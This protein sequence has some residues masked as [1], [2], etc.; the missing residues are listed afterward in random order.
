VTPAQ[1]FDPDADREL[2]ASVVSS[3]PVRSAGVSAEP[4]RAHTGGTEGSD[5]SDRWHATAAGRLARFP[6]WVRTALPGAALL[7]AY[8]LLTLL[9]SPDGFLGTDTGGKVATLKA[10]AANHTFTN[11]DVGYWAA[12]WDPHGALH[13]LYYTGHIGSH[14]V[15]ATTLPMQLLGEPLYRLGGYRLALLLPIL[16]AVGCAYA[17]RALAAR[18]GGDRVRQWWAFW[19]VG[20]ASPVAIYALDFWEHSIGLALMAW[21]LVALLDLLTHDTPRARGRLG[22]LGGLAFGCAATMRTEALIYLAVTAAVVGITLLRRDRRFRPW[23]VP[24]VLTVVGAAV[25]LA[26]NRLLSQWVLGDGLRESRAGG[27]VGGAGADLALRLREGFVTTFGLSSASSNGAIVL[28]IA[29][30]AVLAIAVAR[31]G[32]RGR[33]LDRPLLVGL[34]ACAGLLYVGTFAGGLG[35]VSGITGAAPLAAAGA[36]LA[37]KNPIRRTATV[38]V[39]VALPVVWA[40]QWTGGAGPQWG[41]RYVLTTMF[42]LVVAAVVAL[43]SLKAPVP[44]VLVGL[45]VAV[46]VFGLA[47]MSVRTHDVARTMRAL[48]ARP[49]P[50][51]IADGAIGHLP[52]EGGAFYGEHRW[53][54][55]PKTENR[56]EAARVVREAGF[57][58][59]AMVDTSG[60]DLPRAIGEFTAAPS[61]KITLFDG[62]PLTITPYHLDAAPTG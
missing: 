58:S 48:D 41:G 54:T 57:T 24:G 5:G 13:P 56:A 44:Q 40:F 47:W 33:S 53:L 35:W 10:M 25:P 12:R 49:E 43:P 30:A 19:I 22:L 39:L 6:S 46:T 38:A 17:A 26:A 1:R 21:G 8:Y 20:L 52:R 29:S 45:A 37:W 28:G 9:N 14:W 23:L 60:V 59:F 3:A 36:V 2:V 31:G 61:S 27:A 50:V 7:A 34:L 11:V 15:Q 62:V 55:T 16:G 4:R 42:V 18:F 32:R 51:L